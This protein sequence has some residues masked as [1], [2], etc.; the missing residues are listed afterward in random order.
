MVFMVA[1]AILL[2]PLHV[3]IRRMALAREGARKGSA[4]AMKLAAVIIA[5]W[6]GVLIASRL[7]AQLGSFIAG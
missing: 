1:G 6:A 4:G 2:V 5:M 7:T 3:T